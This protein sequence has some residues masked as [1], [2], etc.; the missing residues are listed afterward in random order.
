MTDN[1]S[2]YHFADFTRANYRRLVVLAKERFTFR[3]FTSFSET[4]RFVIWRHDVDFSPH[5]A[6]RLADIEAEE[7]VVATYF[8]HLHNEFYNLLERDIAKCVKA[9]ISRGHRIGLHFDH[10]YY[11]AAKPTDIDLRLTQERQI[12]ADTFG[13]E[14]DAF[15]FHRPDAAS[16]TYRT[17][18]YSGMVNAY[19]EYFLTNLSYCSDSNG[20]WRNRRLEE[21][22]VDPS[23]ERLQVLTHPAWWQDSVMSPR[24]RIERCIDGRAAN[25]RLAYAEILRI[26]ERPN[27]DH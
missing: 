1:A 17:L 3:T 26:S 23:V 11:H 13:C 6:R 21:V 10:H 24:E 7:G 9:I 19:A 18:T 4:E 5:S 12:L 27:I 8:L 14:V 16:M 15:S 20:Y 25:T 22:L 2:L